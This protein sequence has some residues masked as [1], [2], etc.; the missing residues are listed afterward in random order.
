[1]QNIY[2]LITWDKQEDECTILKTYLYQ[3]QS[4]FFPWTTELVIINTLNRCTNW[5]LYEDFHF[6]SLLFWFRFCNYDS[7]ISMTETTSLESGIIDFIVKL[8]CAIK[9]LNAIYK[10]QIFCKTGLY[11]KSEGPLTAQ[12]Y[13]GCFFFTT[14]L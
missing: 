9:S 11:I 10:W 3:E 2:Y 12:G 4:P 8:K 13:R 6:F 14:K 7:N 1:M 5:I